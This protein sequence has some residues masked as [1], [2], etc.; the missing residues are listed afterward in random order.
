MQEVYSFAKEHKLS[1]YFLNLV[2]KYLNDTSSGYLITENSFPYDNLLQFL[3]KVCSNILWFKDK[4]NDQVAD[5]IESEFIN[6]FGKDH[7][8]WFEN[9]ENMKSVPFIDH[10]HVLFLDTNTGHSKGK[11]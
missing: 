6:K 10:V 9:P 11:K 3:P 5:I 2:T 8:V 7:V 4:T 1:H